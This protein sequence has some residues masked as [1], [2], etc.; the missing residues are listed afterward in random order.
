MYTN[1]LQFN[2]INVSVLR[3]FFHYKS[4]ELIIFQ[5]HSFLSN[6]CRSSSFSSS[7][8]LLLFFF[9]VDEESIVIVFI[10]EQ[11]NEILSMITRTEEKKMRGSIFDS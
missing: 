3:D 5:S 8:F 4:I 11:N 2:E 9:Y 1:L 7:F 6:D 10:L